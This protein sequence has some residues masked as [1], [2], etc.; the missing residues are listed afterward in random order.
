MYP[1]YDASESEIFVADCVS[2]I[3]KKNQNLIHFDLSG[4]GLTTYVIYEIAC[5]MRKSRSIVGLH[6][7]ENPG[8]D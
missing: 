6:L 4:T 3:I 1:F 2:A 8:V 5:A 7:S